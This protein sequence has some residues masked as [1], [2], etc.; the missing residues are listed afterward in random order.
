MVLR[1]FTIADIASGHAVGPWLG[2]S[3][4]CS[5]SHAHRLL[6][7]GLSTQGGLIILLRG[8]AKYSFQRGTGM[9]T[10][11]NSDDCLHAYFVL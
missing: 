4:R 11:I 8:Q 2:N 5:L 1:H 10:Q 3:R 9:L 6:R 7:N